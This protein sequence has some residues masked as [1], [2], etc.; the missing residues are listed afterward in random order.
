MITTYPRSFVPVPSLR[1]NRLFGLL[2]LV[3]CL[4]LSLAQPVAVPVNLSFPTP[5]EPALPYARA[6]QNF[7]IENR[8][9]FAAELAAVMLAREAQLA[10]GHDGRFHL[11]VNDAPPLTLY[12]ASEGYTATPHVVLTGPLAT[13]V[14]F[15]T[16]NDP[17]RWQTKVPV[18]TEVQLTGVIPQLTLALTVVEGRLRIRALPTGQP[19]L[20]R[21]RLVVE[22]ATVVSVGDSSVEVQVGERHLSLP[23]LEVAGGNEKL[24]QVRP[25]VIGAHTV[26]APIALTEAMGLHRPTLSSG[27]VAHLLA[28]STFLGGPGGGAASDS[29]AALQIDGQGSIFVAGKTDSTDFP[30]TSGA[31]DGSH[32]GGR[33]AF[34]AKLSGDLTTLQAATFLGGS[35][36]DYAYALALD[37]QGNVV[38]AGQTYSA[39]FPT[40]SGAYD[41]SHN[42]GDDAFVATLSSDLSTLQAATFLGGSGSD[43]A[44]A[45]ALDGQGNVVVAGYTYSADFPTT[46]GAYDELY[47]GGA[48]AFVATLSSD[49]STLQAATFLGGSSWDS[50]TA[51]AL[52]GQGNVVVV[53][54]TRS[55]D[56]PTTPGAFD[57][58]YNGG[59]ADAFVA[60]LSFTFDKTAPANTAPNQLTTVTLAW[61]AVGSGV[62]HY[63]YCSATTGGCT[64]ATS[65]GT[66]TSVTLSGLTPGATYYWQVRACADSGCTVYTDAD[67][68]QHYAFTVHFA[69]YLPLMMR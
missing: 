54:E 23:L 59:F 48:D 11:K 33:D 31:Y 64:P 2:S 53:G 58:S 5:V 65:V 30:T 38:V 69:V 61:Q 32:N 47:N 3:I 29:A 12:F 68:G 34:V 45:L 21:I 8:G 28:E 40:T 17:S 42:G 55:A 4:L 66:N 63:R 18:W 39:D 41:G 57:G 7:F 37:G 25:T 67:T 62:D 50:T 36:D 56:F 51:L 10:V 14:S 16:G 35:G 52:D 6:D 49:L 19:D 46:S 24:R 60:K 43:Y 9:Q 44:R 15:L 22:G 13:Q 1:P 20:T 27:S 26:G